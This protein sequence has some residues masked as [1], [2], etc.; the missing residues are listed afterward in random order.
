MALLADGVPVEDLHP[1]DVDRAF[2][3]LDELRPN[4][5]LWWTSG[6]QSIQGFRTAEYDAGFMWLTRAMALKNEGQPIA[7][8]YDGALFVGD[9]YAVVK[10]AP[11]KAEALRML[12]FFL[13]SSKIQG[14][15]CE[16]LAC[17]PPST[18]GFQYMS[19]EARTNM[20]SAEQIKSK[21][22][23][24][25]AEWINANKTMLIDRWNAWMQK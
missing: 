25:D 1:M 15:I 5:G 20:P 17:T 14:K 19:A 22:V 12:K 2:K 3:K 18:D 16:A 23:V 11:H 4:V 8:S 6:D 21:M 13:D 24:P 10:G 9:R 7:W